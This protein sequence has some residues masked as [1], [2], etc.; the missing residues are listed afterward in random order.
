MISQQF[1]MYPAT[2]DDEWRVTESANAA[3]SAAATN[4]CCKQPIYGDGVGVAIALKPNVVAGVG[5]G[6]SSGVGVGVASDFSLPLC[7]APAE[8]CACDAAFWAP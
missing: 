8:C 1:V 7:P 6:F 5:L 4:V 3:V 2:V